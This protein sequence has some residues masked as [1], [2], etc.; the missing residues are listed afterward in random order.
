M[1]PVNL[2]PPE[3]RPGSR[4]PLRSGPLA[5][6]VV[7]ALAAAVI[8]ITA[9]VVT[10][11]S[12]SDKKVE[13][14]QLQTEQAQI[15]AKAQALAA[16]TQFDTVSEQRLATITELANSRF[17]W[18]RILHELSLVMPANVQLTSLAG[19]VASGIGASGGG[20]VGL[21]S[22]IAG[23]ALEVVGCTT[24][25]A[26]VAAFIEALKSIDGVTRV[27]FQGSSMGGGGNA[28]AAGGCESGGAQ[29]QLVAAFDAAP[30]VRVEE[31]GAVAPE[32]T[33]PEASAESSAEA[34]SSESSESESSESSST[35]T[36]TVEA[37]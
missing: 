20:G 36:E 28:T 7:G 15:T 24:S 14:A 37:S 6:I 10:E 1:R 32:A 8:A 2:I 18:P 22:G 12:I 16:Y 21:R 31:G 3:E 23:P 11:N 30:V 25:Q 19:N 34:T 5:Y 17:D 13:V 35:P 9:L 27:G 33:T 29:F 4:K 26:S